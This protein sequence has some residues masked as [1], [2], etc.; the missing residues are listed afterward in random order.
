MV[1]AQL[2]ACRSA[3]VVSTTNAASYG[4]L[5]LLLPAQVHSRTPNGAEITREADVVIAA[6]GRAQMIRGDW[7]KP[8]AVVIDVGINA[9]DVS[10]PWGMNNKELQGTPCA[11]EARCVFAEGRSWGQV[12][13]VDRRLAIQHHSHSAA[14]ETKLGMYQNE[15]LR[16]PESGSES[17]IWACSGTAVL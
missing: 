6:C 10:Q 16:L 14:V 1:L 17:T 8:G 15:R 9:V 7:I 13:C 4:P 12:L 11:H 2:A 3:S 5:E